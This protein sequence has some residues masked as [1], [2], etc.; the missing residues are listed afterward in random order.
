MRFKSVA[1]LMLALG[2][3]LVA[4]I[5]I[6]Q[7]MAKRNAG[8]AA[9][10]GEAESIFVAMQD[11]GLGEI[12]TA[13]DLRLEPWPKDK[14]PPGALS[15]IEEVE[16]RRTKTKIYSGEPILDKK[17]FGKGVAE[18]GPD[19]LIPKGYRVVAVKVD[20]VSGT[21]G[22]IMPGSRVD[23]LVHLLRNP[24]RGIPET[25]TRVILQDVKVFAVND[26]VTMEPEED[27]GKSSIKAT[28]VSLLATPK[29][30]AKLTL[31]EELGKL[32]LVLRSPEDDAQTA[33]IEAS[34]NELFGL[35]EGADRENETLLEPDPQPNE[36]GELGGLLGFLASMQDQEQEKQEKEEP[37]TE[38]PPPA[39]APPPAEQW[40]IRILK[41]DGVEEVV[42]QEAA[43][44]AT[45]MPRWRL[46]DEADLYPAAAQNGPQAELAPEPAVEEPPPEL[47]PPQADQPLDTSPEEEELQPAEQTDD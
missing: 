12:I 1:L 15:R 34:P 41:P 24:T 16:G 37:K 31:A 45:G 46:A 39:E 4:S 43:E 3:G 2:C 21:A 40:T 10:T 44:E 6:T 20:Q 28:T 5:G 30:A 7:V 14:V 23:V 35:S 8:P 36:S 17:L 13:Q 18:Q 27:E 11:I 9:P 33:Q 26:R 22:M 38:E 47:E 32:R 25:R 19:A 29:Q 42:L